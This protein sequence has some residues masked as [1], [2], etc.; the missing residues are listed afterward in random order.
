MLSRESAFLFNNLILVGIAFAV[1]W[2][3][4][5][6]VISEAV[7]G[8]KI[9]VGPPFFNKVNAPLGLVLLF[10]TGVG[11]GDR[12]AAGH[13]R[14]TCRR[15]SWSRWRSACSPASRCSS[16]GMRHYYAMLSFSLCVFVLTTIVMEFY[17]GVRA[18]QAMVGE[19]PLHGAVAPGPQEPAALRR[20]HHPRRRRDDVPRHHRHVGLQSRRSRSR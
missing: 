3:T 8:V 4:M 18:R 5:F 20:L 6:P 15:T 14:A 10:L 7:R 12:L 13:R 16:L 2:G 11:P 19:D 1:F 9:T 17:R